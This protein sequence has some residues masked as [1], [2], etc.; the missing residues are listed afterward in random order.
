MINQELI[1]R[2]EREGVKQKREGLKKEKEGLKKP[3]ANLNKRF[4]KVQYVDTVLDKDRCDGYLEDT[5]YELGL[6]E[7]GGRVEQL[8]KVD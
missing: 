7:G 3:F 5:G 1:K 6:V 4:M 8:Q 2:R